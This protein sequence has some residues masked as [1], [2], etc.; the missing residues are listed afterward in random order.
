MSATVFI[1]YYYFLRW[2][3]FST[4]LNEGAGFAKMQSN[5]D[6]YR[7]MKTLGDLHRLCMFSPLVFTMVLKWI[8]SFLFHI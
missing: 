4:D 7:Q 1:K 5:N 8:L 3:D 6:S 2:R